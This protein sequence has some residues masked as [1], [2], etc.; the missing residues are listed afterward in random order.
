MSVCLSYTYNP[1]LAHSLILLDPATLGRTIQRYQ[2]QNVHPHSPKQIPRPLA[3]RIRPG[4]LLFRPV[5][6]LAII[7]ISAHHPFRQRIQHHR[8]PPQW[9]PLPGLRCAFINGIVSNVLFVILL[10][11]SSGWASSNKWTQSNPRYS[12]SAHATMSALNG[13]RVF[14]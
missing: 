9:L 10:P 14:P 7:I 2:H 11:L 4:H 1:S 13:C 3:H 8:I 6:P 5:Q 12:S